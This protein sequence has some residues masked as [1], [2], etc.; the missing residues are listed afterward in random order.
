MSRLSKVMDVSVPCETR[1][2]GVSAAWPG[3]SVEAR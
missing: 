3:V 2:P 1:R